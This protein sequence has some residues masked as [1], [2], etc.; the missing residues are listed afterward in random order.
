[1]TDVLKK[2]GGLAFWILLCEG[3]GWVAS[4]WRPGT[5]HAALVKPA[6]NPPNWVFA[7]VWT[8]LYALMGIAAWLV[9]RSAEVPGR[10]A[11]LGLFLVQLVLNGAWSWLFFGRHAVGVALVEIALLWLTILATQIAFRRISRAAA[12]LVVPYLAWV[13]FATALT[14]AIWRLNA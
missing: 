4:Q 14:F 13:A 5:W 9:W 7:P 2:W 6:W 12:W 8:L 3:T 1:M 10:R 11:A